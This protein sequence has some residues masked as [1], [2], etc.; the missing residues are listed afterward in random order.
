MRI[1]WPPSSP[2]RRRPSGTPTPCFAAA[3]SPGSPTS[4]SHPVRWR[5]ARQ[6][7]RQGAEAAAGDRGRALA[8]RRRSPGAAARSPDGGLAHGDTELHNIIVCPAPLEPILVDFEAALRRDTAEPA[9]WEA[10]CK[11][12]LEPLLREAIYL[13]C[14]LG[15]QPSQLGELSWSR[16]TSFSALPTVFSAPS[17]CKPRSRQLCKSTSSSLQDP[18]LSRRKG[19]RNMLEIV[20][21]SCCSYLQGAAKTLSVAAPEAART[22]SPALFDAGIW[23]T[24]TMSGNTARRAAI[25]AA[26][27]YKHA[28]PPLDYKESPA[29][30]LFGT[31]V[32][33]LT[34]MK[35][36]LAE[37]GLQVVKKT[38]ETGAAL[39]PRVADAV[40]AAMKAWALSKGATHYAHVF[41]PLT[42]QSADKH[43]SFLSPDGE[44]GAITEFAG[45]T[46]VQGEPDAS[47]FPNGGIR[48]HHRGARLHGLGRD[49]PRLPAWR[50]PTAPRCASPPRS[51]RGPARRSTRRRRCCV[52]AQALNTQ[53][54]RILKLFGHE[55][56]AMVVSY[57]GAEQEYFLIDKNFFYARP[58]LLNAGPHAVRRQAPQGAGVRG[59]LL[60]RHPRARAGVHDGGRARAVQAGRP[61]ED[62]P[63]RGRAGTVRGRAGVRE[64]RTSRPIT[65]SMIMITLKQVA[66]KH[67][68]VCLLHEKPFA[69]VNG[70]G[71][72][73]NF[74]F[75]NATQGNLLD[76][77]DTPARQRAVPGVLR[78][79]HPRRAQVR[80]A[81]ARR[82]RHAPPTIT[83]WAPTKR[84][85]PSSRS[86]SAS[87]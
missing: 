79:R 84:R 62:P 73:V 65:S 15:R 7:H 78:R 12:D 71:K 10:R 47:S 45:K 77:G 46:L 5:A 52:R 26:T 19:L 16:L 24:W 87:S 48:A 43:D 58:D 85:R 42:G 76:P 68:L 9:V 39:D 51:C 35:A 11:R 2:A 82:H 66:E 22:A 6:Q 55:K 56:P 81:P 17:S 32:F 70:S 8:A 41:Y 74:S 53:V 37:R 38:I 64:R 4:A 75:G 30:S 86:S 1:C 3:W 44:G 63:Q 72:H 50:P 34:T 27:N 29:T 83:V 28:G 18:T 36:H 31:N 23:R 21:D 57:A 61:G 25:T 60:R 67:G 54:S 80:R 20:P 14:A 33:S 49:Q 59:P 69:G 40:A 13:Q